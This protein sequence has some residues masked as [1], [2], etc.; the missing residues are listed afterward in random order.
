MQEIPKN[1]GI[2]WSEI[3]KFSK[4]SVFRSMKNVIKERRHTVYDIL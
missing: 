4:F 2:F 3:L 1:Y